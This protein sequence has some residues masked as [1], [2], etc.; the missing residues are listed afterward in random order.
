M[1]FYPAALVGNQLLAN[2]VTLAQGGTG[3][4]TLAGAQ[5]SILANTLPWVPADNGLLAAT[6][7]L[8]GAALTVTPVAGTVYLLK[9]Q[10]RQSF[11]WTTMNY[12]VT[13]A[14]SGAST[15][16]FVGLYNSAGTLLTGSADI[17]ANLAAGGTFATALTTP[18]ALAAGTFVWA[19]FVCN[20]ATTQPALRAES[21]TSNGTVNL[22]LAA[23]ALRVATNGTAQTSLP[24]SITPSSNTGSAVSIWFGAS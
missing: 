23:S 12:V 3:A 1:G 22:G 7:T 4:T 5:Q 8:D 2:P 10:V 20:L 24:A 19:T 21:T 6:S 15:G 13:T 11:T 17:G 14:G 16:S 18:Q 9:C